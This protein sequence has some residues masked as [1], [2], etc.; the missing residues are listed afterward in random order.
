MNEIVLKG[1]PA[2]PGIAAGRTFILDKQE[3][4][5]PAR[6]V[7]EKEVPIEIARFEE[8]LI[9]T[10]E[11]IL[12]IQ[13]K[14][15]NEIEGQ[16]AQIFDAHLLVLEDRTLIE[17]V[18]KRIKLEKLSAEYIFSEVLKRY[19]KIFSEIEDEYLKERFSDVNDVGRRVLKNLMD[20][21]KL[22]ELDSLTEELIIVS[23]DLSPSDTASMYNKN[24]IAL[25][26]DIGGRTSHTAIMAKSLGVPAV[27]G[28]KDATLRIHNQDYMIVDG[29]K[30]LVIVHPTEDTKSYYRNLQ[31]RIVK[32]QDQF[33]EI[34]ELPA[35]TTDGKKVLLMANLELP[36]EIPSI[37]KHGADGIGL[38]RT[39]Y[40]YMNRV[41]LP[42]VEEQ[43][44][45]YKHVAES[46][47]PNPV[48][49]R[50]LDLGGDKFISS[51][52]I[53]R[54]MYPF[55]GMR[56]IRFCL[57]RPD[58]FK[59]QLRA[60]LMASHYGKIRLIYPMI[61]GPGELR[62]ANAILNEVKNNLREEKIP[63]DEKLPV[64][65]MI[66]VPSAA[67]T[68]DLLAKEADFFSIGTNDLIQY[69][70]A[71]DRVNELADSLYEPGH[72]AILRL[73]KRTI[74]A[75]HE[76]NIMVA[77]CG[78]MSG[79]PALAFILLGLNLDEFSMSPLSILQIKELIRSV[80]LQEAQK[81]AIEVLGLS[82]GEEVE[83]LSRSRLSEIAPQI[84]GSVRPE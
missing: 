29:R 45:I 4:I 10:R 61:S 66:E 41:D 1:I 63:F 56:A 46:M 6:A 18:I 39:E 77:L 36:E 9:K 68:A 34:K 76:A 83:E 7:M 14:I 17:E 8:A 53:P 27:V 60:I 80:S 64:G 31:S 65:V 78:E 67:I 59:T 38:F 24:I 81:L 20:E 43:F 28:L 22:H 73:I 71:V 62:Q 23:H 69:T 40:F 3:F 84:I 74:D 51:L 49:I 54:D 79:E 33:L 48:T 72:P 19:V 21:T 42:T 57:A 82:T 5:V 52:E 44:E 55:L 16:H 12:A 32:F 50:S 11:E 37:L 2:A 70:L 30:G 58:I 47:A 25:A 26:T 13:K 75:A 35:Q 15:S